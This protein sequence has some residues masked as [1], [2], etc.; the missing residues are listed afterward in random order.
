[1]LQATNYCVSILFSVYT[2]SYLN[3]KNRSDVFHIKVY[4]LLFYSNDS[5]KH[6]WF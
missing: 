2:K 6:E 4:F 1:M 5:G 3:S